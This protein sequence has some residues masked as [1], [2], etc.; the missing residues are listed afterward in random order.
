MKNDETGDHLCW[1][2]LCE[3]V[4]DEDSRSDRDESS[5]VVE[6]PSVGEKNSEENG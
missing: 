2:V 4:D 1:D 3:H 5:G 6:S